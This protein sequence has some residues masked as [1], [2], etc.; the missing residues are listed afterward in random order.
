M[1]GKFFNKFY[2]SDIKFIIHSEKIRTKMTANIIADKLN[3]KS[4]LI[5]TALINEINYGKI[6]GKTQKNVADEME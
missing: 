4:T 5:E 1:T 3:F 2:K 6:I